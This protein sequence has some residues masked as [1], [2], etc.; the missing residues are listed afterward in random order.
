M[1]G[2]SPG[3]DQI[4]AGPLVLV[5]HS[6]SSSSSSS[7]FYKYAKLYPLSTCGVLPRRRAKKGPCAQL[8]LILMSI[9]RFSTAQS[10]NRRGRI[11]KKKE[12]AALIANGDNK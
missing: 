2:V 7:F 11:E 3:F 1:F 5:F 10:I 4:P 9:T 8:G 6:F 12:R